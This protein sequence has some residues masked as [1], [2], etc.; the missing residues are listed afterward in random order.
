[1]SSF[2]FVI[3]L[4]RYQ[5]RCHHSQRTKCWR[6]HIAHNISIIVLAGPDKSAF[7]L[8]DTSYDIIDQAVEIFN[9]CCLEFL[10]KLIFINSCKDFLKTSVINLGDRILAAKPQVLF[11]IQ[12][13]IKTASC[14]TCDRIIQIVHTLKHT[15]SLIM[16]D[17]L[18][19]LLS[20]CTFKYQISISGAVNI[21]LCVLIHITIGMT[22]DGDRFLPV[23]NTWFN[24]LHYDWGTKN[25][26][27]ENC[28]N[29]SVRT[30]VHFL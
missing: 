3:S 18:F 26:S 21:H 1:M 5:Y 25:S 16:M 30:L 15:R 19:S 12:C 17:Q 8:H 10:L 20:V 14:K 29:R 22:C 24:T 11:C 7:S 27:V 9:A 23:L 4:W 2:I 13:I 6:N 28:T